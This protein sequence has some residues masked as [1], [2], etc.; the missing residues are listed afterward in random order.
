MDFNN[1]N[2]D[3]QAVKKLGIIYLI[4]NLINGKMYVGQTRQKLE[5]RI[6]EHKRKG[7]KNSLGIDGA[8]KKYGWENFKVEI[9]EECPIEMLNEREIFW[10]AELKT[11]VPNGYNLTDG[12]GGG[13]GHSP[14]AE[15]RAKISAANKGRPAPNKGKPCSEDTRRKISEANKGK[16]AYNKGKPSPNKG[17]PSHR[18]GKKLPKETCDKMS[19]ARMGAKN[20]NYGKH[21]KHTEDTK[22]KIGESLR[23]YW[24]KKRAEKNLENPDA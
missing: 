13:Y 22:A 19:A 24:A 11:K 6:G 12:G 20:P 9:L 10:I 16:P 2:A 15:T 14:S 17:K 21:R 3:C 7:N 18:K 1:L 23:A 4:I 8:I 5:L